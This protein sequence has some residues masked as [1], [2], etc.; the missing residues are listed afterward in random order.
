MEEA[1][2]RVALL[3]STLGFGHMK[4]AQA[5]E[6]ALRERDPDVSVE[7]IDFW[8]LMD[9][10]VAGA[11]RGGYLALVTGQP[12]LYDRLYRFS[13]DD[14]RDF[15]RQPQVPPALDAIFLEQLERWFSGRPAFPARGANLD[16]TLFLNILGTF[17]SK[18]LVHG[19]LVRR[20]LVLWLHS[21]L[22][23]RLRQRL[24]A[25]QPDVVVATQM[26]PAAVLTALKRRGEARAPAVAVITDYGVHDFWLR[27][28]ME[29]FCVATEAMGA[30]LRAR[31]QTDATITLSG[32]PL[33]RGFREPPAQRDARARLEIDTERPVVLVTGGG[34]GIGAADALE[35]I[36][37]A[38]LGCLVLVA[39][40]GQQTGLER[41][42]QIAAAYP[43]DVCVFRDQVDMPALVRAADVVIGKPGGLSVSEAL[44]CGR[45]FLA[46]RSLGGQESFNVGYLQR[47]GV[48]GPVS[49]D[50]LAQRLRALIDD[51]DELARVQA[52]AWALGGRQG[53]ERVAEAVLGLGG[54]QRS[55]PHEERQ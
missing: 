31:G 49:A 12:E 7:Y 38:R 19:N 14:W 8:S 26:M 43:K 27:S 28:R 54:T 45:P 29:H 46:V 21:R 10:R 53:A 40:A 42:E 4:A 9:E 34:Y 44:A 36:L 2:M 6:Q 22:T 50:N 18:A 25:F 16:Q 23:R 47:H 35:P 52:K 1:R 20:G 55:R 5:V 17:E 39:A 48:G 51:P 3:S 13:S 24:L 33:M 41:L 11:I 15:F 37:S 30:E 32:I